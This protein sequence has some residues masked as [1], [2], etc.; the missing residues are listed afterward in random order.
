MNSLN[1]PHAG[2]PDKRSR[3][4]SPTTT[5]ASACGLTESEGR[6]LASELVGVL[7]NFFSLLYFIQ[8]ETQETGIGDEK[9]V[10]CNI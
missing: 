5:T 10:D 2:L 1:K 4:G 8:S 9:M 3:G 7:G 6:S